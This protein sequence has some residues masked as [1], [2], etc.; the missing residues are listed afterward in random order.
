MKQ[1]YAPWHEIMVLFV[2]R[3]LFLQTRMRSHPVGLDVLVLAHPSSIYI[4]NVCE[5]RRLWETAQMRMLAWA[6]TGRL[7]DKYH[8]TSIEQTYTNRFKKDH[9]KIVEK[10]MNDQEPIQSNPTSCPRHQTGK[11]H[12]QFRQHQI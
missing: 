11:E 10:A 7:C 9:Y 2:L 5:Q 4:L 3:K 12:K 8:T 6:F 1:T